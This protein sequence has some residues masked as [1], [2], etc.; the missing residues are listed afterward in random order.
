MTAKLFAVEPDDVGLELHHIL[1]ELRIL[2]AAIG[3]KEV[4]AFR[5]QIVC[6]RIQD[7]I[8]HEEKRL[9][10]MQE[11]WNAALPFVSQEKEAAE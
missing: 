2:E 3:D 10:E 5:L 7:R 1:D 6:S 11:R 8:E 4:D 9:E